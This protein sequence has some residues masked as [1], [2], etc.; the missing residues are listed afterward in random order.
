MAHQSRDRARRVRRAA[1]QKRE[2]LS[3]LEGK[4]QEREAVE[5]YLTALLLE[6]WWNRWSRKETLTTPLC[7]GLEVSLTVLQTYRQERER[8]K[9]C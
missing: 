8:Q 3:E 2:L 4:R 1:R 6:R 5:S 7:P 9:E